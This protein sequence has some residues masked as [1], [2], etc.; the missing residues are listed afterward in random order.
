MM[1]IGDGKAVKQARDSAVFRKH[2]YGF[3]NL[4]ITHH[5]HRASPAS[6]MVVDMLPPT[7]GYPATQKKENEKKSERSC[8]KCRVASYPVVRHSLA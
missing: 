3:H 6:E 8:S 4:A 7:Q 2:G 5:N 1:V